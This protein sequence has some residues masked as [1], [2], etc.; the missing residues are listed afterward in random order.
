MTATATQSDD[1]LTP[2]APSGDQSAPDGRST[3]TELPAPQG[4]PAPP[5]PA[6]Y[7]G[8]AGEIA[9]RIA[10]HTEADPIAILAQLLVAFGVAVGRNAYF[11]LEATRHHPNAFVVLV[12]DSSRSRKGTAWDHAR[13]LILHADPRLS[14]HI[15][16]GLVSGEGLVAAVAERENPAPGP[17][18]PSVHDRRLLVVEPEFATVL[19][20]SHRELSTLSPTL[21]LA[22]DSR[23]LQLLAR[24]SPARAQTPHISLI[25]HITQA[26][27][28][29]HLST[30]EL[31]NGLANRFIWIACR[32][33]RLLPEGGHPDPLAGT[34]LKRV[35]AGALQ[36]AR[37]AGHVRFDQHARELWHW[38]YARL[39]DPEPAGLAGALQARAE[40]HAIRLS[41][42]YALSDGEHTIKAE[43]LRAAL[44]LWDYAARSAAWALSDATG[45]PLAEQ[46]HQAL[47]A[48][49]NGL[50]RSQ[51]S[52]VLA[53]NRSA[54]EI[55]RAL[56]A[57]ALAGRVTH[58][59]MSTAGRPA[60]LWQNA[61]QTT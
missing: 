34:G 11:Q 43:H 38:A 40:A 53:H 12:G 31:A 47:T 23:P 30:L 16:S 39:A 51:I 33:H 26:E 59:K 57:L 49:P 60:E 20:A 25:G 17:L 46:I 61:P 4:F 56:A 35:L 21:R 28:R 29:H 42:L 22:W 2:H 45:D 18:D 52:D 19:K 41:L 50:T 54:A 1:P 48:N 36:N 9:K 14:S 7:C 58:R 24:T 37:S 15:Q 8:L 13:A 27:L 6:V 5:G 32:R 55:Q 44:A 10:P 3:G